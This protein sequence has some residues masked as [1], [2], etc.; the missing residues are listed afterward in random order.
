[1]VHKRNP[2]QSFVITDDVLRPP[3]LSLANAKSVTNELKTTSD[4]S[5]LVTQPS[6]NT[7]RMIS[8]KES[9]PKKDP[10]WLGWCVVRI[11]KVFIFVY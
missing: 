3:K 4:E 1:M 11:K 8:E 5:L 7:V 2:S 9:V 6:P 10:Y